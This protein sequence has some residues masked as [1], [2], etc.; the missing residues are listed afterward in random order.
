MLSSPPVQHHA[1]HFVRELQ[2]FAHLRV[3]Q[4][5]DTGDAVADLQDCADA[6]GG[7]LA[8]G[9]LYFLR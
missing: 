8:V 3:G 5:I 4:P 7:R 6:F 9:D 1:H 2:Q